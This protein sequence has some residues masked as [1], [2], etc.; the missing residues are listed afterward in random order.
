MK[1]I[2]PEVR[3]IKFRAWNPAT[4]EMFNVSGIDLA[5][6][7]VISDTQRWDE[8]KNGEYGKR[9]WH[10][11]ILIQFTGLKDKNGKEIYHADILQSFPKTDV[12]FEVGYG[13]NDF[14]S[15]YGWNLKSLT[16]PPGRTYNFEKSVNKMVVIGNIFEQ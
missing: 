7:T 11:C 3:A 12:R 8:F 1:I 16:T 2:E 5:I 15:S 6:M 9:E 14:D 4:K 13:W 10:D